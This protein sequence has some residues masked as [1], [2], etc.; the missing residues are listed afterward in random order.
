MCA[1]VY[2]AWPSAA[3]ASLALAQICQDGAGLVGC[4]LL[5]ISS[6]AGDT[7]VVECGVRRYGTETVRS[8]FPCKATS[9]SDFL[10]N[11]FSV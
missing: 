3:P 2:R 11:A 8:V 10:I 4:G 5:F 6:S 7:P 9:L 1:C